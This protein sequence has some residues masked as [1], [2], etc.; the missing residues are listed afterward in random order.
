M[1][2]VAWHSN[3]FPF[4]LFE[5]KTKR[6]SMPIAEW[7]NLKFQQQQRNIMQQVKPTTSQ[8]YSILFPFQNYVCSSILKTEGKEYEPQLLYMI[9]SISLNRI[10]NYFKMELFFS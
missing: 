9:H 10:Y 3:F 1:L 8:L 6:D 5:N 7:I 2:P 4:L